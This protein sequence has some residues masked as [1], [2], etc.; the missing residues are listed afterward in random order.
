M[1]LVVVV[2]AAHQLAD[3][4]GTV[5]DGERDEDVDEDRRRSPGVR[6]D[7]FGGQ[8]Q[9]RDERERRE[10]CGDRAGQVAPGGT[11]VT[12]R[13]PCVDDE[14]DR[15]DGGPDGEERG[16]DPTGNSAGA[17][18]RQPGSGKAG[19]AERDAE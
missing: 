11:P 8:Q 14:R 18:G 15:P 5:S 19:D 10:W 7:P 12:G 4:P 1:Q 9:R 6:G 3:E 13:P 17:G 2:R 16:A